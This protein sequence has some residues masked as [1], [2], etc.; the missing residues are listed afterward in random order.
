MNSNTSFN[1]K[2]K[3]ELGVHG[4]I[5]ENIKRLQ[6]IRVPIDV[7]QLIAVW[8]GMI[9]YWDIDNSHEDF[10][11]SEHDNAMR[12]LVEY[13]NARCYHI[14][15]G[16]N[17]KKGDYKIWKLKLLEIDSICHSATALIGII[18]S[19]KINPNI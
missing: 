10:I 12:R 7:V 9:D 13:D 8:F 4:Y 3:A 14:Y 19:H 17:I 5:R 16:L 15:G 2:Q 18:P 6:H 1:Y 11:L